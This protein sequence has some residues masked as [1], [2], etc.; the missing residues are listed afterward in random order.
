M[1]ILTLGTVGGQYLTLSYDNVVSFNFGCQKRIQRLLE[2]W[3]HQRF[4]V[5]RCLADFD[6]VLGRLLLVRIDEVQLIGG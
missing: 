3:M 6:I 4:H 2:K 1:V 5:Q